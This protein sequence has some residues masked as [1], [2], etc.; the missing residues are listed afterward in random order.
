VKNAT[1]TLLVPSFNEA[2]RLSQGF[3]R[4]LR[5]ADEG[6]VDFSSLAVSYIDDGSTDNTHQAAS[7]LVASLPHGLVLGQSKNAGKGSAVRAGV[8][9]S[10]TPTLAFV[11]ADFAIDPRQLPSLLAALSEAPIA[12]GSRAV[13]G[14]I[15]YGSSIRTI[16]GRSFNRMIRLVSNLDVRDTQ[17]GFKALRTAPAKVLFHTLTIHGFSFDVELLI[18][19]QRFG[20]AVAEVPVSWSDVTGS[21]VRLAKDSVEML[22]ELAKARFQSSLIP[23]LFGIELP[24]DASPQDI[25]TVTTGTE[26]VHSPVFTNAEGVSLLAAAM[27]PEATAQRVLESLSREFKGTIRRIALDEI[28]A[29]DVE[30]FRLASKEQLPD[31]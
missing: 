23:D 14:H 4:L 28:A 5:A 16:A 1:T 21:H 17:C 10:S 7:E 13:A 6:R 18:R 30:S 19:A 2:D 25:A 8:A 31:Q 26:L 11:D 9:A 12:I 24:S 22:T 29:S 3:N 20:W 27:L 15:D